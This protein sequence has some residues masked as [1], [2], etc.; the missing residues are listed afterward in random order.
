[1]NIL[2]SIRDDEL[3]MMTKYFEEF[4]YRGGSKAEGINCNKTKSDLSRDGKLMENNL[5]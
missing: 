5:P 3:E 4:F 2:E 1:M